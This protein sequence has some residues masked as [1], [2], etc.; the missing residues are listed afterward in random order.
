MVQCAPV[1]LLVQVVLE[2]QSVILFNLPDYLIDVKVQES[3]ASFCQLYFWHIFSVHA[4]CSFYV[5]WVCFRDSESRG[6]WGLVDDEEEEKETNHH[7]LGLAWHWW[8]MTWSLVI[9]YCV[10]QGKKNLP[11]IAGWK[12][13][14][15]WKV[16]HGNIK[17]HLKKL[18]YSGE[19]S[20][21]DGKF[22]DTMECF[23]TLWKVLEHSK[24]FPDYPQ[25]L[26]TL[27]KI[28]AHFF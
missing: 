22:P 21:H 18:K 23:Q 15:I 13:S 12:V 25:N 4:F 6:W 1:A 2:H 28:Y 10:R 16:L 5:A 26:W 14:V 17:V 9:I 19:L 11:S 24:L 7:L 8:A 3:K 20:R 27:W